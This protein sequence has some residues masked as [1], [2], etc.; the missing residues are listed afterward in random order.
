MTLSTK[1]SDYTTIQINVFYERVNEFICSS[2]GRPT[3]TKQVYQEMT[4]PE[5]NI[6]NIGQ[7]IYAQKILFLAATADLARDGLLDKTLTSEDIDAANLF[8]Q[9]LIEKIYRFRTLQ[10]NL[11]DIV[12][13]RRDIDPLLGATVRRQLLCPK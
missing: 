3:F 2:S 10:M 7:C 1:A 8:R 11:H 12:F 13:Y 6:V 4:L 9:S 5:K